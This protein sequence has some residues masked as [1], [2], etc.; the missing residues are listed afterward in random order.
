MNTIITIPKILFYPII[1]I[2]ILFILGFGLT[3]LIIPRQLKK[4]SLW[5][6][7]WVT[8]IFSIFFLV[9]ISLFGLSVKQA[10]WPL[11]LCFL[12]T[13]IYALFNIRKIYFK[14]DIKK[15]FFIACI[16]LLSL[17]LNLSPLIRRDRILT[18][19]SLGNNDII[20]Y[21]TVGDYLKNHSISESFKTKVDTTTDNLLHD[22]YR[23]GTPI[24][25]S[26]F[27]SLLNLEGY[28]YTYAA[29]TVLFALFIPLV[30]ILF[31]ILFTQ[32]LIGTLIITI[33]TGFNVNL[34]YMLYHDFFGQ[35]LFWGLELVLFIL[36]YSYLHSDLIKKNKL[37][38]YDYLLGITVTVLFFSYHEPAF[39]MFAPIGLF[40]ILKFIFDKKKSLSYIQ[41]IIRIGL[42]SLIS[43]S[44]S[45]INAVIF[46]FKQAFMSNPNQPIG[47]QLFRN[48]IPF[49]NPFE[50]MG[51]YSI[52]N[53]EPM[54][55]LI[56]VILSVFVILVILKGVLN[57]K[58][59]LLTICNLTV[60]F[61]FLY[62]TGI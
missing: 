7:P 42:I 48:K 45:I 41:A 21:T 47:W 3:Q 26:F 35:V 46:D 38:I 24:I 31:E 49:A 61:F 54:P 43:G 50:A 44:V 27:L 55:T 57:S 52:H 30:F 1:N 62:W 11:I 56:A 15:N 4:Y 23:W 60:F 33:L 20:A 6:T 28:Q 14:I 58:Y 32:S 25:N 22:G 53:F 40:I 16:V 59:R 51:F 29:Q 8:I 39:F 12:S 18:T 19:I 10:I 34:L 37:N 9:I 5:L 2:I 36:F 13:D 17:T